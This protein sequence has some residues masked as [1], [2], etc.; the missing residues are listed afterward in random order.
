VTVLRVTVVLRSAAEF[1]REMTVSIIGISPE[2]S[3]SLGIV[4]E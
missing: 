1:E 4:L 3:E 2:S